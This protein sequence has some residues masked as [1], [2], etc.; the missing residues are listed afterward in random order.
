MLI[1]ETIIN[2]GMC[3]TC[4]IGGVCMHVCF[5]P[6]YFNSYSYLFQWS[7]WTNI[8]LQLMLSQ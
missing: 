6:A 1:L 5:E 7:Y 4:L 2:S 3:E 8:L